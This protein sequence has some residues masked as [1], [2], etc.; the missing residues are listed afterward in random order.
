[1]EQRDRIKALMTRDQIAEAERL[2][3]EWRPHLIVTI[4]PRI[5]AETETEAK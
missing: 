2:A 4:E 5:G 3:Q 1:L